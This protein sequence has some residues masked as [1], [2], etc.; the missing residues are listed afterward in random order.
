MIHI[1]LCPFEWLLVVIAVA[2]RSLVWR[3]WQSYDYVVD[4]S[5]SEGEVLSSTLKFKLNWYL[6]PGFLARAAVLDD[7]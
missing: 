4:A 6:S 1:I 2:E 3:A 7:G 5:I